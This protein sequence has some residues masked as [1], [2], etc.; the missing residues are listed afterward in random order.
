MV[1]WGMVIDLDRCTGCQACV[2]ACQAENNIPATEKGEADK[3]RSISWMELITFT[4]GHYP[5]VKVRMLPRPCLHCDHPPCVKVC[6]V[7]ALSRNELDVVVVDKDTCTSCGDCVQACPYGMIDLG[8]D[9][10]A[11]K[12]NYCDGDPACAREC[13]R[14][15][16]LYREQDKAIIKTKALQMKQ[17]STEGTPRGKRLKLGRAVLKAARES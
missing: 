12:C 8:D 16:L 10:Q 7:G 13:P 3:G 9:D 2:V 14:S 5:R 6:P 15:A 4:E 17:R 1:K 11:Y